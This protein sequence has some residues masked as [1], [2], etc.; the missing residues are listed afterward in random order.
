MEQGV[1]DLRG[2]HGDGSAL[3][4]L[5]WDGVGRRL[6]VK[7]M[8]VRVLVLYDDLAPVGGGLLEGVIVGWGL[9]KGGTS[10]GVGLV[11]LRVV[12]V[13]LVLVHFP[14]TL[15]FKLM[16]AAFLLPQFSTDEAV[17]TGSSLHK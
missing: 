16:I 5:S 9:D 14:E 6:S 2:W 4:V 13:M 3:Y 17:L 11:G 7:L 15:V 10:M 8:G 12:V 1:G